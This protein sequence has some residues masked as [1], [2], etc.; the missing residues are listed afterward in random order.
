MTDNPAE[1]KII[2][3]PLIIVLIVIGI[4]AVSGLVAFI[5]YKATRPKIV[6]KQRHETNINVNV[7]IVESAI[8]EISNPCVY[9]NNDA[10]VPIVESAINEISNPYAA[11]TNNQ[12][13]SFSNITNDV[14]QTVIQEE[15][16]KYSYDDITPIS[17]A[18]DRQE[19][20][21]YSESTYDNDIK[22]RI[23]DKTEKCIE[24]R[25]KIRNGTASP[26]LGCESCLRDAVGPYVYAVDE[27]DSLIN[28]VEN[29]RYGV[30]VQMLAFKLAVVRHSL[31][32]NA[33]YGIFRG[34]NNSKN[35]CK[36]NNDKVLDTIA[37]MKTSSEPYRQLP[38]MSRNQRKMYSEIAYMCE[39]KRVL[40]ILLRREAATLRIIHHFQHCLNGIE[41]NDS[42]FN[43][44][45]P[46]ILGT[47]G[48]YTIDYYV[49]NMVKLI[50]AG[51]I[52][53]AE[54][55]DDLNVIELINRQHGA[56]SIDDT[57]E[58]ATLQHYINWLNGVESIQPTINYLSEPYQLLFSYIEFIEDVKS[59][60]ELNN[61][62]DIDVIIRSLRDS[63]K[64]LNTTI[65]KCSVVK[66][67]SQIALSK[68][69]PKELINRFQTEDALDAICSFA[70]ESQQN[71][72]VIT[73]LITVSCS[74]YMFLVLLIGLLELQIKIAPQNSINDIKSM[75][76]KMAGILV[77]TINDIQLLQQA[78]D[79]P[80]HPIIINDD[81]HYLTANN[82][83][84]EV[85]PVVES[86]PYEQ[87]PIT[88]NETVVE[89]S[90]NNELI[91]P[92]YPTTS[93]ETVAVSPM[94][95]SSPYE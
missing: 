31:L 90:V 18:S 54:A 59:T 37:R 63:Y 33:I 78:I 21:Q 77:N 47:V 79:S 44:R 20:V 87:H 66:S 34:L 30:E 74:K 24:L 67:G 71:A 76:A 13:D 53:K 65:D 56:R 68:L 83:T 61:N 41:T 3:N 38:T 2:N 75:K 42:A 25:N 86:N 81:L 64:E 95:G 48:S 12:L 60:C 28:E 85:P 45:Y 9:P 35:M 15:A 29:G 43:S 6:Q 27:F 17:D 5:I 11:S 58:M 46:I 7:P 40:D 80:Q 89:L 10:D 93:D 62:V 91:L 50:N 51:R 57:S 32:D 19:S 22:M 73:E 94:A 23:S 88:N 52:S 92:Q 72:E 1:N 39:A 4:L 26:T 82:E 8:N 49:L 36:D 14:E 55:L 16:A 69:K 84:V 70:V